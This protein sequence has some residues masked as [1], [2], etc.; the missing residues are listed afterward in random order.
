MASK[1]DGILYIGVTDNLIRRVFEHKEGLIQG[2]TKKYWAKKLVYFEET[3][4]IK[5][6]I[7][8]EKRIKKWKRDWKKELIEKDN[9]NWDDLYSSL[10]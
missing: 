7:S 5:S 10:I 1:K 2:F 9:P 8:R 3:S 4:D 6:A